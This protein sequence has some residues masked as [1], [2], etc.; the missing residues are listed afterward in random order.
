MQNIQSISANMEE[1]SSHSKIIIGNKVYLVERHFTG[2]KDVKAA[3]YDVVKN[4]A[5]RRQ[6]AQ[7]KT[8]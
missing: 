3:I 1:F 7:D 6:Q 5:E 8:A 4:E 2:S